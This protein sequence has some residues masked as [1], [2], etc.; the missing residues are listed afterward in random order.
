MKTASLKTDLFIIILLSAD[1][2]IAPAAGFLSIDA[3]VR[4]V[5]TD[6]S[7]DEFVLKTLGVVAR[8]VI[9][10]ETADRWVLYGQI[11]FM[12]NFNHT[13]IHQMYLMFKGPMGAWNLSAGRLRLPYGLLPGYATDHAGYSALDPYTLGR[14]SDNGLMV[15]GTLGMFDYGLAATRGAGIFDGFPQQGLCSGRLAV[16]PG[17]SGDF[18]IG[19]SGAAGRIEASHDGQMN[20]KRIR[21]GALDM[22]GNIGRT[23]LRTEFSTG[24]QGEAVQTAGFAVADFAA[25]PWLELN[26]AVSAVREAG[27]FHHAWGFAGMTFN[28]TYI[29][30]KGGYKYAF[31][32][33]IDHQITLMAYKQFA[34]NY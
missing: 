15:S 21:I 22:I 5:N 2:R 28:T 31:Y 6:F 9:A 10:D 23:T 27:V 11:E 33:P 32:G 17:V 14:E 24:K 34:F 29:L 30:L 20:I 13:D 19:I 7:R 1:A 3:D 26:A 18:S 12:E 16:T 4:Y 8:K 25:L